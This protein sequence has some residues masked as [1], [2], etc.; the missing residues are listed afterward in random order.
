MDANFVP[1]VTPQSG[2]IP[3]YGKLN[4]LVSLHPWD[5]YNGQ[6]VRFDFSNP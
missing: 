4:P 6:F 3:I 1:F 5:K 2:C